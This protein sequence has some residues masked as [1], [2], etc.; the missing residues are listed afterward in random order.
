MLRLLLRYFPEVVKDGL[1]NQVLNPE[2]ELDVSRPDSL[3]RQ[4]I[5]ALRVMSNKLKNAHHGNQLSFQDSSNHA[6]LQLA[7]LH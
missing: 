1:T 6:S 3:V 5:L 2:V 7:Y 4:Q